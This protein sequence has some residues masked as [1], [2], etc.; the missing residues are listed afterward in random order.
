MKINL[1]QEI[2]VDFDN[3]RLRVKFLFS[4]L[5]SE[6]LS[7]L[8]SSVFILHISFKYV[9]DFAW[10]SMFPYCYEDFLPSWVLSC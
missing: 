7:Y 5:L 10:D 6:T 9:M 3:S 2:N 1:V 4:C 8:L